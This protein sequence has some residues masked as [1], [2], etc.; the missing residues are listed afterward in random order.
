MEVKQAY[1][2][3]AKM[4]HPDGDV[5]SAN[6]AKFIL[7][8]E[9]YEFLVDD[10]RRASYGDPQNSSEQALRR[11][12]IYRQWV[13]RQQQMAYERANGHART[14]FQEFKQSPIYKTAMVVNHIYNYI[15]VGIGLLMVLVPLVGMF[16]RN[17]VTEGAE[18]TSWNVVFPMA[19]GLV[20]TYGVYYF[21][22]KFESD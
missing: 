21:L 11:E 18:P 9:A 19:V 6:A 7:V 14:S 12:E 13:M 22:F 1:R 3:L 15:F 2:K 20:F 8:N 17:K 16:W 10:Q 4:Y 5:Q